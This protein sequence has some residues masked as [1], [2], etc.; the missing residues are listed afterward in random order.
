LERR[1]NVIFLPTARARGVGVKVMESRSHVRE[2]ESHRGLLSSIHDWLT[3]P[4]VTVDSAEAPRV[5]LEDERDKWSSDDE[6]E[7]QELYGK[8]LDDIRSH[9]V[10]R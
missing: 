10:G 7:L 2:S 6:D 3:R 1:G 8:T 9:G 5:E 4:T